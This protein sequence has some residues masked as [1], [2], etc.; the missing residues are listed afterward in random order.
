MTADPLH[1]TRIADHPPFQGQ[2]ATIPTTTTSE[3][4]VAPKYPSVYIGRKFLRVYI[5]A[6]EANIRK[7]NGVWI[8]ARGDLISRAILVALRVMKTK[9]QRDLLFNPIIATVEMVGK[10]GKN[11]EVPTIAILIFPTPINFPTITI[12][13]P[14][15]P[16]TGS[17]RTSSSSPSSWSE[18]SQLWKTQ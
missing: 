6:V 11:R 14:D 13:S 17:S 7:S 3:P 18:N 16:A 2:G 10:D 5:E 9:S 4:Y 1:T 12:V 15:L 8:E